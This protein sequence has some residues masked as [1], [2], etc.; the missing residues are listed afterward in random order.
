VAVQP[1]EE[2]VQAVCQSAYH[3]T[4]CS[5]RASLSSIVKP[6]INGAGSFETARKNETPGTRMLHFFLEQ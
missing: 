3:C 6:T 5:C 4:C 1:L 2:I